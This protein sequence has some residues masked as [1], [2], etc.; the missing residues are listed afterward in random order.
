MEQLQLDTMRAPTARLVQVLCVFALFK[1]ALSELGWM[2]GAGISVPVAVALAVMLACAAGFGRISRVGPR[3]MV[4]L[5][6]LLSFVVVLL[7]PP[8]EWP[9]VS[10]LALAG[11]ILLPV[12]IIPLLVRWWVVWILIVFCVVLV[13][14]LTL[15][16]EGVPASTRMSLYFHL[17]LAFASG[18][19]LRRS[20][21]DLVAHAITSLESAWSQANTDLLTRLLNRSGWVRHTRDVLALKDGGE[22]LLALLFIDIDHFKQLNDTHGHQVGDEVLAQLGRVIRARLGE[23][24]LGARLGGEELACLLRRSSHASAAS[25]AERVRYDFSV[26]NANYGSTISVGIAFARTGQ[27]LGDLMARADEAM[28][29]AKSL[30]R[31]Q[32]VVA[33]EAPTRSDAASSHTASQNG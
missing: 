29:R 14:I 30:G 27:D 17:L 26:R 23:E 13:A 28:Y 16:A 3:A 24:D 15:V 32:V 20:R 6:V 10:G 12:M 22:E 8:A 21:A 9:R 25:F 7:G 5:L 33:E 2:A 11:V 4:G 31:D 18:L 1:V 19:M